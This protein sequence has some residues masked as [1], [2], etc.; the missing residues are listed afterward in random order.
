[1]LVG[2]QRF[3]SEFLD[4]STYTTISPARDRQSFSNWIQGPL[5]FKN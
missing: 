3:S 1:M 4:I 2:Y 5:T